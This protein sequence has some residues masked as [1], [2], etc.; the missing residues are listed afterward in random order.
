M[1]APTNTKTSYDVNGIREDLSDVI[2]NVS[3]EE[4]P[5][6]SSIAKV[7]AT[8]TLHEWQADTLRAAVDTN[9]HVSWSW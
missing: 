5:F 2:Y 9:A 4:T 6:L 7:K 8:N 3:P 1:T